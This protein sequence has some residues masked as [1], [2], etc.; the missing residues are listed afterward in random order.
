MLLQMQS[1]PSFLGLNNNPLDTY[2]TFSLSIDGHLKLISY[3][4]YCE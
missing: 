1:L 3:L 2:A 4:G